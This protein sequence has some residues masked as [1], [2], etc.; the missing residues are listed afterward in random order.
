MAP[1]PKEVGKYHQNFFEWVLIQIQ[2]ARVRVEDSS[3][4][5]G[6]VNKKGQGQKGYGGMFKKHGTNFGMSN[7]RSVA[8]QTG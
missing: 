6:A 4:W 2:Q 8:T 1:A 3:S 7:Q 5:L